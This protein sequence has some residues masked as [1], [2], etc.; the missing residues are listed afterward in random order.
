MVKI[1]GNAINMDI[2]QSTMENGGKKINDTVFSKEHVYLRPRL[3]FYGLHGVFF[4]VG[5]SPLK[6]WHFLERENRL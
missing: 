1:S 6:I 4:H 3:S 2:I 5:E